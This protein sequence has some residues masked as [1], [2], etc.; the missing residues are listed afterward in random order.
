MANKSETIPGCERDNLMATLDFINATLTVPWVITYGTL[1]GSMR[2]GRHISHET[3][4][5]VSV[6]DTYWI[7]AI[8]QLAQA[9]R[10][11]AHFEL[12]E[13]PSSYH[14]ARVSYSASNTVH[15]DIWSYERGEACSAFVSTK[16]IH[17]DNDAIF[18]F[19]RCTYEHGEYPCPHDSLSVVAKMYGA[20]WR[21]PKRK[22]PQ[23]SQACPGAPLR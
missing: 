14:L 1:L 21:T 19:A 18:P 23:G 5:D 11:H 12:A 7:E 9:A 22:C 3:D 6:E 10:A 8:D 4:I 16:R 13:N 2:S 20:G 15:T 17:I